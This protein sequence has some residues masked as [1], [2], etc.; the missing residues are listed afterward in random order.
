MTESQIFTDGKYYFVLICMSVLLCE[1][2]K[3]KNILSG[4]NAL[5][6]GAFPDPQ[7]VG[8]RAEK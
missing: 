2:M 3:R 5:G 4:D 7:L 1:T 8:I 6:A